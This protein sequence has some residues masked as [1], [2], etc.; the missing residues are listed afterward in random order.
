MHVTRTAIV[1][2]CFACTGCASLGRPDWVQPGPAVNQ[3]RRAVRF[4]P[5]L[6]DDI[7]PSVLRL[8]LMDGT[9]PRDFADPVPEVTR[10]R[11]W[12]PVR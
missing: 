5:Y 1:I 4:D 9:R 2:C 3:R 6:Q 12:A 11:W 8:P 7:A 10:S